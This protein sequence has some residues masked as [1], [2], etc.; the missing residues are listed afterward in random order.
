MFHSNLYSQY[1]DYFPL[2]VGNIFVYDYHYST[3]SNGQTI[4]IDSIIVMNILN[5]TMINGRTYYFAH[6]LYNKWLRLDSTTGSLY[7]YDS[8]GSCSFYSFENFEDSLRAK[9]NDL[10]GNM[11]KTSSSRCNDTS[12]MTVFGEQTYRKNFRWSISIPMGGAS[13]NLT[14][15]KKFGYTKYTYSYFLQS[16]FTSESLNLK[17]CRI[18]GIVYGDTSLTNVNIITNEIPISFSLHQ[19]YPNPFNPSTKIKFDVPKGSLVKLKIYD[20]LGRE[21][22][23]LVNEKLNAGVYEYEWNGISLPSGVYFYK[24]EAENYIETKRMVLIK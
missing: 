4:N 15:T 16:N 9:I 5:D 10:N 22:A 7:S 14:F 19:N 11:C 21:V 12:S 3:S 24:I 23:E 18:N 1:S 8:T 20:V 13:T 17:G 2:Q 6:G